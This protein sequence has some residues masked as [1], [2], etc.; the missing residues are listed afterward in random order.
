MNATLRRRG[1]Q[2]I[3]KMKQSPI[4]I[5]FSHEQLVSKTG[6][7]KRWSNE[8]QSSMAQ[9]YVIYINPSRCDVSMESRFTVSNIDWRIDLKGDI[10]NDLQSRGVDDPEVLPNY[11]YRDDAL[12][13]YKAIETY[14]GKVVNGNYDTEDKLRDDFELSEWAKALNAAPPNGFGVKGMPNEGKFNDNAEL[15][16]V[17]TSVIANCSIGHAAANFTQYD[18][19]ANPLKHSANLI[20]TPPKTKVALTE[21]DV[22]KHLPDKRKVT[23]GMMMMKILSANATLSLGYFDQLYQS[24][25]IGKQAVEEF[26]RDLLDIGKTIDERNVQRKAS[27]PYLHP[28][29]LPNAISI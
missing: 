25:A 9:P 5:G 7:E 14:V 12:L 20:G 11:P 18:E 6:E 10:V 19:Y 13:T 24:D 21:Q 29:Q 4:P 3:K 2:K 8:E 17:I 1:E 26:R 28:R 16:R 23:E 27:Y 22:L 15:I